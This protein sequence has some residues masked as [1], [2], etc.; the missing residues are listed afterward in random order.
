MGTPQGRS[1]E[2]ISASP[3]H[4]WEV[5]ADASRLSEWVPVVEKVTEHAEREQA[6]SV[7]RCEVAMGGRRGYMVE[8]CLESVSERRLRHAVDDDSL[9]LTKMFRDYSFTLELESRGQGATLVTCESFYEPRTTLARLMNALFMRRRF[10]RVRQDIL[11]GLKDFAESASP[12][13]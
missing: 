7:R 1:E 11:S 6:G 10:A 8:R 2:T 13:A 4:V 9:G 12:T 5:L 3:A